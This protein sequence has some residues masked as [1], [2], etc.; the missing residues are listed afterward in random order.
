MVSNDREKIISHSGKD[1]K[2]GM[3]ATFSE[4][5]LDLNSL[6]SVDL[7]LQFAHKQI[8]PILTLDTNTKTVYFSAFN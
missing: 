5:I 8:K 7:K 2:S 1:F 3:K 4:E 6:H